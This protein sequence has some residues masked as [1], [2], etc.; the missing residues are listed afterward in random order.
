MSLSCL[1]CSEGDISSMS[2]DIFSAATCSLQ[3]V[4]ISIPQQDKSRRTCYLTAG[5]TQ[6]GTRSRT[7]EKRGRQ[8]LSV[9]WRSQC[10]RRG[11]R[12][13]TEQ[14]LPHMVKSKKVPGPGAMVALGE[15]GRSFDWELWFPTDCLGLKW[16]LE[17]CPSHQRLFFLA[18]QLSMLRPSSPESSSLPQLEHMSDSFIAS[19]L[20]AWDNKRPFCFFFAFFPPKY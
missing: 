8:E 6:L 3:S 14:Y 1:C 12:S 20:E 17:K 5:S 7:R 18:N 10:W 4:K 13:R 19:D 15:W 9:S 16:K 11:T 2:H